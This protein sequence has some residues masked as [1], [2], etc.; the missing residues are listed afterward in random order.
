MKVGIKLLVAAILS[1]SVGIAAA[2][3]LL[4]S[5]MNI[6]PYPALPQGSKPD[7][8]VDLAYANFSVQ[9]ADPSMKVPE[10]YRGNDTPTTVAYNMVLNITNLSDENVTLS[11]IH[12]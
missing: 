12:I 2:S 7:V 1:L 10:W 4:I 11:L 8:N 9:P 3:P 6:Q 5:E